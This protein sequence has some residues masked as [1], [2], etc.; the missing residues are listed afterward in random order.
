VGRH[1]GGDPHHRLKR[2]LILSA[3][4]AAVVV[5]AIGLYA[6]FGDL[7]EA[8]AAFR[9]EWFPLALALTSLNYLLRFWRWQRYL[10]HLGIEVPVGRSLSIFVAGL[11]MTISPA[12]LGEVLKSGLLRRAFDVPVMR[13]APIV[14]VERITDALGLVLLASLSGLWVGSAAYWPL[15]LVVLAGVAAVVVLLRGPFLARFVRLAVAREAAL[16]LLSSRLLLGMSLLAALSWFFEGLAAYVCVRGL[17]LDVSLA[18]TTFVFCVASLAGALSF[19]PG[20]VGVAETSMTAL[21]RVL[22]EVP[23]AGA[24]AATVLIRA[25]TL[26]YAVAVGLAA[27]GVEDW[28]SRRRL[29]AGDSNAMG[30]DQRRATRA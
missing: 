1:R 7:G 3:A 28:L 30:N 29:L 14:L 11:T 17:G 23:R 2:S 22:S 13:S 20:G 5:L 27:L 19:L 25:A 12:K 18:T 10:G 21:F 26:W 6:D 9:W 16:G 8:L 15:A 4:L 24:A